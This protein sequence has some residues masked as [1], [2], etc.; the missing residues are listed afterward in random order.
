MTN[1][2][3]KAQS[4]SAKIMNE[5]YNDGQSGYSGNE[6][7]GQMS[8]WYI[9]SAM[10]FYPVNP[11]NGVYCFGSPQLPKATIKL[12]NGKEFKIITRDASPENIY[13]QKILLNG[14]TYKKNFIT[15]Q[16]ITTGGTLEYFM[17]SK[18]NKKMANWEKPEKMAE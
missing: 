15:H 13:I 1:E 2:P 9:F 17:G 3:W 10:G 11:A 8:A 14:E 7:C 18:P 6:D 12:A 16:D 4:S 5:Q